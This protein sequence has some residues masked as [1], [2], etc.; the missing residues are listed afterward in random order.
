MSVSTLAALKTAL[1]AS[2]PRIVR[3]DV[4]P[5]TVWTVGGVTI[6]NGDLTVEGDPDLVMRGTQLLIRASNVILRELA[7]G[8][9]DA[10]LTNSQAQVFEPITI[11]PGSGSLSRVVIQ[12][13]TLI[14]GPDI[15]GLAILGDVSDVTVQDSLIGEGLYLSKHPEGN[16]AEGGHSYAM[17][18][19]SDPGVGTKRVTIARNLIGRS[20]GRNP[21]ITGGMQVELANNVIW[22]WG[23][24]PPE[25][26]GS[27]I[28]VLSNW[29]VPG[30]A[31][32]VKAWDPRENNGW[33]P[34]AFP[35]SVYLDGNER[36]SGAFDVGNDPQS[37]Y[38]TSPAFTPT[39]TPMSAQAARDYV[40]AHAGGVRSA[41]EER[42]VADFLAGRETRYNGTGHP[43]P[44]PSW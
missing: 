1:A 19:S 21:K 31:T 18:L 13:S 40:L 42:V 6:S 38:R 4:P 14:W 12:C 30:A 23:S 7:I 36:A 8:T 33:S 16:A 41:W 10:D 37:V 26:V 24:R 27:A 35:N 28:N 43:A 29:Y 44:N 15:G 39:H 17:N 25:G 11:N 2:G 20:D 5:G 9:G 3:I 32:L 34:G 22:S